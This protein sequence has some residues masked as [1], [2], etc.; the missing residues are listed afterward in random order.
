VAGSART[1]WAAR[2]LQASAALVSTI[3]RGLRPT[4]FVATASVASLVCVFAWCVA[5]PTPEP[6]PTAIA[7][8]PVSHLP[9]MK[10]EQP[11]SFEA[12]A[13]DRTTSF[14]AGQVVSADGQP[15]PEATILLQ[16]D[17]SAPA[18]PIGTTGPDGRFELLVPELPRDNIY[19]LSR[20]RGAVLIARAE[21]YG[22]D[23]WKV[24]PDVSGVTLTLPPD[25]VPIEGRVLDS[26]G[27]PIAGA[28]IVPQRL[29]IPRDQSLGR[30][31]EIIERSGVGYLLRDGSGDYEKYLNLETQ[32]WLPD[33]VLTD[34]DGRFQLS[35]LGQERYATFR[36]QGEGVE[37]STI[38]VMTRQGPSTAFW[39]LGV[40]LG[41]ESRRSLVKIRANRDDQLLPVPNGPIP[42][43]HGEGTLTQ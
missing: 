28:E 14:Y 29:Y 38:R 33:R 4:R 24:G 41:S 3:V 10:S 17:W 15:I 32:P 25:D 12:L 30:Y 1:G 9:M 31:F 43:R 23:W 42:L 26:E 8:E 19:D 11:K 39:I 27:Q 40:V 36:V 5:E 34:N 6:S 18:E 37:P 16:A 2:C 35:G 13:V 7:A 20:R 21:G 22:P